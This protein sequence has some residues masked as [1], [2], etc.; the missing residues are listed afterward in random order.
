MNAAPRTAAPAAAR[1]AAIA[2][3]V[4]IATMAPVPA[5]AELTIELALD[6]LDSPVRLVAPPGDAR[7]FVVEQTGRIKVFD[8]DG[9]PRGVF[10][11]LTAEV[12]CC[13]ERGLLGLVF[14]PDYGQSGRFYVNYT[15][16]AG[17]TRVVRYLVDPS[18]PDRAD[19]DSAQDI[20]E[21]GQPDTNH[22]AGH[23]EF[24]PDG[25]L[26]V[27]MGDGG[28]GG[29]PGNNAQ[30]PQSL[31]GKMLRL[32]VAGDGPGYAIPADNPFVDDATH[33]DE[34]WALGLRNPWCWSFDSETG[35]L[36]IA[37]VGQNELEEIDF[38][39]A[40]SPG[41]E[42][43]GWRLMEGSQC[44]DPPT[45]CNDGT[46]TLPIHE[47]THGGSPFRC[48]ISGGHVYRGSEVPELAGR[49]LF[50][51]FCSNQIWA[52][53]RNETG[54]DPQIA[55]LSESLTPP[56]GYDGVV[57]FGRDHTGELYVVSRGDGTIWRIA[58]AP[59]DTTDLPTAARLE[60]NVPNPFNPGTTIGYVV[61]VG[62]AHVTLE[63]YDV[64][65]RLL[66][67]LIDAPRPAGRR[68]VFWDGTDEE[69]RAM[70]AGVYLY[71]LR[72]GEVDVT[73]KMALLE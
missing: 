21:I 40:G 55:D 11:D 25:L 1:G 46:L 3:V 50:S 8:L 7:L 32:D 51:D 20:I 68:Q 12:S 34:I 39:P 43:Y 18:D 37:D 69:G 65:G 60:Q 6:G 56:G 48:S 27:G 52:L 67:T 17:D 42:N 23:L 54:G 31:L 16:D 10:L 9:A 61:P 59:T 62:G 57:S 36:W 58:S 71:R 13:G 26:Y 15:D 4:A 66:N 63:V 41:G 22:N 38:Q 28:G 14:A 30:D 47:Y 19:P 72:A 49:Y 45:D 24:G 44:F 29:D 2:V 70:P 64:A 5:A 35:D 53:R 33:R 73:R